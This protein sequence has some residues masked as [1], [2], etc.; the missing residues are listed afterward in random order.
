MATYSL[1][2]QQHAYACGP[3]NGN[4]GSW[5]QP[6]HVAVRARL[7]PRLLLLTPPA[8]PLSHTQIQPD[9]TTDAGCVAVYKGA[10]FT[11]SAG[12]VK[13]ATIVGASIK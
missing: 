2:T 9:F 10:A 7:D 11:T 1:R 8:P 5:W 4:L 12:P 3:C 6:P 13:V